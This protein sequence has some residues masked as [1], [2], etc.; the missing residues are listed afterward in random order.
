VDL[1]TLELNVGVVIANGN[2]IGRNKLS[3]WGVPIFDGSRLLRCVLG[4]AEW[5]VTELVRVGGCE[6]NGGNPR[7]YEAGRATGSEN[8]EWKKALA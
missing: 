4:W 3:H 6:L 7:P 2:V 8:T 1:Q 5:I